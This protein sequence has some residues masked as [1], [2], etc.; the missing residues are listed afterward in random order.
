M[1]HI[2]TCLSPKREIIVVVFLSNMFT[3]LPNGAIREGRG[4]K[5]RR[6]FLMQ[7]FSHQEKRAKIFSRESR[8]YLS[9]SPQTNLAILHDEYSYKKWG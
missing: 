3:L 9:N 2:S 6:L 7:S 5:K 4:E 1:T 8:S